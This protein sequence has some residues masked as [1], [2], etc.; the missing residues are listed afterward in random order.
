MS[1]ARWAGLLGD[2]RERAGERFTAM[3]WPTMA[4][5]DWRRTDLAGVDPLS[6]ESARSD[7]AVEVSIDP[8]LRRRG[9]WL[10]PLE[11]NPG[12]AADAVAR[13]LAMTGEQPADRYE[14]WLR[15]SWTRGVLLHVPPFTEI[16]EPL[17]IDLDEGPGRRSSRP[18]VVAILGEGSRA[19]VILRASGG[20]DLLRI[21]GTDITV[22]AGARLRWFESQV[23]GARSISI[24]R[25]R[26]TVGRDARFERLDAPL[27]GRLV[28]ARVD[29]SLD[30]PGAVA[31]LHG[32]C[33]PQAGQRADLGTVQRHLAPRATSRA[34]FKAAVGE[35][36][37]A[38]FQGLIEVLPGARGTDAYLANRNLLLARGARADSV[39]TLR[40]GNNDV[41]CSHGS[42][43][44]RLRDEELF[45]LESRG[46]SR[47]QARELLVL[48][49]FED[50]LEPSP[51]AFSGPLLR[52]L[53]ERLT[54]AA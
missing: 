7:A 3:P 39:P 18:L 38:V 6:W 14:A 27:G 35:G 4:D 33:F 48:G 54:E 29:C 12:E 21:S 9:V 34:V 50:L 36:S 47:A 45:Y 10:A 16:E 41:K 32:L 43:T 11:E 13:T 19:T 44:G 42:T 40:I 22:G 26:V 52:L 17:V 46:L 30:G 15:S 23:L 24:D 28:R 51:E 2:L 53:H 49:F 8:D 1:G 37:R 31:H 5:E 20:D 25:S